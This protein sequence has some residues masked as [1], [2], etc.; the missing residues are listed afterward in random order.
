[1]SSDLAVHKRAWKKYYACNSV[2]PFYLT[3]KQ[4]SLLPR[5]TRHY[6]TFNILD[7][8]GTC[9]NI[10]YCCPSLY[11]LASVMYQTR[12]WTQI[13]TRDV[14][15]KNGQH[16]PALLKK[17][18]AEVDISGN[19]PPVFF[20]G[21]GI[22]SLERH[23]KMRPM[24]EEA[25]LSALLGACG[26]GGSWEHTQGKPIF[27]APAATHTRLPP[28]RSPWGSTHALLAG[29]A[30]SPAKTIAGSLV[31]LQWAAPPCTSWI[32]SGNDRCWECGRPSDQA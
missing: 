20:L 3:K 15:G 12:D 30:E 11:K 4:T 7:R 31:L 26:L 9:S 5:D 29:Q 32:P 21:E 10:Q 14:W 16:G 22:M 1:M 13:N 17:A 18:F 27:L 28:L 6:P 24:L 8:S 23:H 2:S 19:K 25:T